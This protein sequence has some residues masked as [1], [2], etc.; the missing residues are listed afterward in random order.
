MN[1]RRGMAALL[2][3][4]FA[5][6]A[7][8]AEE[9]PAAAAGL[10]L[11]GA[12]GFSET[13]GHARPNRFCP[14]T[15]AL[16]NRGEPF[17]GE[18]AVKSLLDSDQAFEP[19]LVFYCEAG[20]RSVKHYSG[21]FFIRPGEESLVAELRAGG[22]IL[23]EAHLPIRLIPETR[24][25]V[26]VLAGKE[27]ALP[28]LAATQGLPDR[29]RSVIYGAAAQLPGHWRGYDSIDA[30]VI[31]GVS[32]D[33][34]QESQIEALRIYLESGG[35]MLVGTGGQW[36]V[37]E[38]SFLRDWLPV[39]MKETVVIPSPLPTRPEDR[40]TT[41]PRPT[42]LAC[43]SAIRKGESEA[44]D[45]WDPAPVWAAEGVEHALD[46][47]LLIEARRGAGSLLFLAC[48]LSDAPL[49][50]SA[51]ME[52][53][54]GDLCRERPPGVIEAL[55]A[56]ADRIDQELKGKSL[57]PLPGA[58][59]VGGAFAV[60]L[61]LFLPGLF[62]LL[63]WW[64][65]RVWAW[66]AMPLG[67]A[68]AA[69]ALFSHA[70]SE[71]GR[72][73]FFVQMAVAESMAGAPEARGRSFANLYS[74]FTETYQV[75]SGE[76]GALFLPMPGALLRGA[77]RIL[78]PYSL[79][80]QAMLRQL[81]L[82]ARAARSF[83]LDYRAAAG[84]L[85]GATALYFSRAAA[86][87][88]SDPFVWEIENE[89]IEG[90]IRNES[91]APL[92]DAA[93]IALGR[94]QQLGD[95]APGQ[96]APV[97]MDLRSGAPLREWAGYAA[98]QQTAAALGVEASL[99]QGSKSI[100]AEA[101]APAGEALLIGRLEAPPN[102]FALG[103]G[104]S[105]M[106]RSAKATSAAWRIGRYPLKVRGGMIHLEMSDFA[107]DV[108]TRSEFRFPWAARETH[109]LADIEQGTNA[110][111]TVRLQPWM[112]LLTESGLGAD[113]GAAVVARASG[114]LADNWGGPMEWFNFREGRWVD[115]PRP[116]GTRRMLPSRQAN[117]ARRGTGPFAE[118]IVD[119]RCGAVWLR[120]SGDS[121]MLKDIDLHLSMNYRMAP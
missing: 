45:C 97:R 67:F 47:P 9:E 46:F 65:G 51:N 105:G 39:E 21:I 82:P 94:A 13:S 36:Q 17:T 73:R 1:L 85:G 23:A 61:G 114:S 75:R 31:D 98:P 110:I 19:R 68:A 120:L 55:E 48:R 2:W 8:G 80:P 108:W 63:D 91:A 14:V 49:S 56:R 70:Q 52:W 66:A 87:S 99:I 92:L 81:E 71:A 116:A 35:R 33:G 109:Y 15:I 93:L 30:V 115:A 40:A 100:L 29:R 77:P 57:L 7:R 18:I 74:P 38:N 60:Y 3:G 22:R 119:P 106:V 86:Q 113:A 27:G 95:L 96:A 88:A 59:T 79:E 24:K 101:G 25:T 83:Q 121:F 69:A 20:M 104:G 34:I 72:D 76:K 78:F 32:L 44:W 89:T 90:E 58:G 16:D 12:V 62:L 118:D 37:I 64:K 112:E 54:Y 107:V 11:S 28:R 4:T 26:L 84:A 102:L 117:A 5:V 42:M 41:A 10:S 43:R 103:K 111:W 53:L 50:E 6:L